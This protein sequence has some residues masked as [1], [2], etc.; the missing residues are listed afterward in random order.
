MS[1]TGSPLLTESF[2]KHSQL[3]NHAWS[4]DAGGSPTCPREGPTH[5]YYSH[6]TLPECIFQLWEQIPPTHGQASVNTQ[7][8]ALN[9]QSM[10][11]D[12]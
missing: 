3:A 11:A 8:I 9:Q 2:H 6:I 7:G 4:A 10:K 5:I 1:S 12:E